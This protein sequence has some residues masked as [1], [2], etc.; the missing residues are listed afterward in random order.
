MLSGEIYYPD[1]PSSA[2]HAHFRAHSVGLSLVDYYVVVG[3]GYCV[4][5]YRGRYNVVS[6]ERVSLLFVYYCGV[7]P[8]VCQRV[9]QFAYLPLQHDVAHCEV[10][11]DVAEVDVC[12]Y[13]G[14]LLVYPCGKVVCRCEPHAGLVVVEA[15]KHYHA[16]AFEYKKDEPVEMF[17][18]E[19]YKVVHSSTFL[20][21]AVWQPGI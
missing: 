7:C 21:G 18:Y 13:V 19:L 14:I 8:H 20:S 15:E 2:Y 6:F 4:G 3:F 16:D 1:N 12:H 9:A 17:F 11:V 10:F 5:S